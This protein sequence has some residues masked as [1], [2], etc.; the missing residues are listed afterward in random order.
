MKDEK[1]TKEQL[2]G[3]LHLLR[4]RTAEL[5]QIKTTY[6][7][8]VHELIKNREMLELAIDGSGGGIWYVKLKPDLSYGTKRDERFISPRMKSFIGYK[9]TEFPNSIK[10]W[11]KQCI[12]EDLQETVKIARNHFEG[13][14]NRY[15]SE[16]RIRHRD[17]SIR[18]LRSTGKIQ[19][20]EEGLP[21]RWVGIE[22]D[23]SEQKKAEEKLKLHGVIL[24]NISEGVCLVRSEDKVIVYT[25][26][27]FDRMFGY[28]P[29]ELL[30]KPITILIHENKK[31]SIDHLTQKILKDLSK[32]GVAMHTIQNVKKVGTIFW[33]R[34]HISE[35]EHPEYGK[36]WLGVH[37]DITKQ[38]YAEDELI[39]ANRAL[40][41]EIG[42]RKKAEKKLLVYQ[43]KLRGLASDMS[44]TTERESQR[45]A[46]DLHDSVGQYLAISNVKLGLLRKSIDKADLIKEVDEI[47]VL[48]DKTIQATRSLI[49][50]LCPPILHQAG[51]EAAL[52]WLVEQ[53]KKI[54]NIDISYEDDHKD[55]P[56]EEDVRVILFRAISE[57]LTNVVKHSQAKHAKIS[58]K[59]DT[60][61]IRV[62]V[63]D[64]G[65]GFVLSDIESKPGSFGLFNIRE[66]L[67]PFGGRLLIKSIPGKGTRSSLTVPL[68]KFI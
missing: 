24:K 10:A 57:L 58:I 4:R 59:R 67:E 21:I 50:E 22:W 68:F 60:N 48:L 40:K 30:G 7:Q 34:V 32:H 63:E 17:G 6:T 25:N 33:C 19:R 52:E 5:E 9:D 29:G 11:D 65:V 26:P 8:S 45:L 46:A 35:F 61:N 31:G 43:E 2:I 1:K 18:W 54:Q 55:K 13:K 36:V 37:E 3:E 44:F 27:H 16:Y 49:F 51:L 23:I 12:P 41:K 47:R 15:E 20:N 66:R 14:T 42:E 53:T 62:A 38:K 39:R 64:D 28:T 56:L